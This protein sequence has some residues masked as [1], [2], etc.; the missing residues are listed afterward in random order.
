MSE[1]GDLAR[2]AADCER[3]WRENGVPRRARAQMRLELEQ[4]LEA[5]AA[6]GRP[7]SA[8]VGTNVARFAE[9]WAVAQGHGTALTS[10]DDVQT[11]AA[12]RRRS[13]RRTISTY[14]LGMVALVAGVIVGSIGQGGDNVDNE[15]WRWVWTLFALVMGIGEIF[16]AGF[17]LLPF[18][19]GAAAAAVT[20]WL[21]VALA[22]QWLVFFGVSAIAFAYL[23]KF[24]DRQD[25]QVQPRI[26]A[27]RWLDATGVVL[28]DIDPHGGYG[29]VRIDTEEWRAMSEDG[30][31]ILA[32]TRIIVTDVQGSRLV[33]TPLGDT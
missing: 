4:H 17:F 14:G 12:D 29:M 20:A 24:I 15:T 27:N 21:G 19:I 28:Q 26:G 6:D 3:Y 18:A 22:A 13:N 33:V 1:S 8:V 2:V 5:A 25:D 11:G 30:T 31:A 23:R 10:W 7:A 32:G 9:E 16:T